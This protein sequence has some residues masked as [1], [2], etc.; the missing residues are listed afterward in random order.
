M[1]TTDTPLPADLRNCPGKVRFP[2]LALAR[3]RAGQIR[4]KGGNKF[5][6]YQCTACGL[7]HLGHRLGEGTGIRSITSERNE[8]AREAAEKQS[9]DIVTV[10][11]FGAAQACLGR[12]E[13]AESRTTPAKRTT[14]ASCPCLPECFAYSVEFEPF[15]FWAGMSIGERARIR[16]TYLIAPA[17]DSGG[18][19]RPKEKR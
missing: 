7:W 2:N 13:F 3:R 18:N 15:G 17:F 11:N 12:N 4:R 9:R 16:A 14:C 8:R 5:R 19:P 6:P 10:P 1:T